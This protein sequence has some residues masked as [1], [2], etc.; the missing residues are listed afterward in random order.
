MLA[1]TLPPL[2]CSGA[3][4]GNET[5]LRVTEAEQEFV[6]EGVE[7]RPRWAGGPTTPASSSTNRARR[8]RLWAALAGRSKMRERERFEDS[9]FVAHHTTRINKP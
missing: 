2:A 1:L 5:V 3:A 9:S 8:R 7:A 6:F 4:L